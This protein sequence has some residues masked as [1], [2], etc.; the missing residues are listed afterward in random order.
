[1]LLYPSVAT[2]LLFGSLAALRGL[3]LAT[4]QVRLG[5][6]PTAR[7]PMPWLLMFREFLNFG[8]WLWAFA[9]RNVMYRGRKLRV[10]PGARIVADDF[11][12]AG[13]PAGDREPA[14]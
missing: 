13:M 11:I 4:V 8:V 6:A 9:N 1:V 3:L 5:R 14:A 12:A 2:A 7:T 10:L